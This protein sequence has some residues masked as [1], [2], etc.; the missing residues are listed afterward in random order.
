MKTSK[1]E[2]KIIKILQKEK[3]SFIREKTFRD[4]RAGKFRYDFFLPKKKIA[5]EVDGEQ[6]FARVNYFQKSRADFLRQQEND[7]RKN[8]YCLANQISLYRIPYWDLDKINSFSDICSEE[9]KVKNRYHNDYLWRKH[10]I[11]GSFS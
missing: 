2:E 4:L 7:R 6:H 3:I 10:Q 11:D 8:S 9:H 5:L 1:G